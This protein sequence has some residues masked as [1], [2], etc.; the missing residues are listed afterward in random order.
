M[1]SS[2]VFHMYVFEKGL[3]LYILADSLYS[4]FIFTVSEFALRF[5]FKE[6]GSFI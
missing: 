2:L 5:F 4:P 1:V 6:K 3:P